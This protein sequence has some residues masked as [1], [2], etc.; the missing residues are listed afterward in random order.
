MLPRKT[1]EL[2]KAESELR[3]VEEQRE[4]VVAEAREALRRREEGGGGDELERRGRWLK[5]VETGLRGMLEA[6]A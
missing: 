4:D 1:R 2:E 3:G 5:G 6:E